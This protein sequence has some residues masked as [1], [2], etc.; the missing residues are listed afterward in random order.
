MI[1][2]NI[3]KIFVFCI[4]FTLLVSSPSFAKVRLDVGEVDKPVAE[5]KVNTSEGIIIQSNPYVERYNETGR[6]T[7]KAKEEYDSVNNF[8]IDLKTLELRVKYFSP[9]YLNIRQ[10]A[11][12][13][14]YMAYYARGGNDTLMYDALSYTEEIHDL[15]DDYKELYLMYTRERNALDKSDPDYATKYATLTAQIETYQYMH[16]VAKA[17]YDATNRTINSTKTMLGL[18]NALYNIGNVDNNNQITFAREAITKGLIT[19]VLSVLQLETYIDILEN[20]TNLYYD[21]YE[22]NKKNLGL[23]LATEN[24]VLSSYS[25][26][27]T[28]KDTLKK[29][30][31]TLRNVKEQ[32]ANNLG[33]SIN[34]VDKLNFVEPEVDYEY[35]LSI[36]VGAD[37]V[38]AYTSNSNYYSLSINSRDRKRPGSTGEALL[39]K[40]QNYMSEKVITAFE[41]TYNRL[42]SARLSYE[43]GNILNNVCLIN[44]EANKRKLDNN[45]VSELEYKGLELQNFANVL[46]VRVSKYSLISAYMDYYYATLGHLDIA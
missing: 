38:K 30:K 37:E 20:Q 44:L 4:A 19:A 3:K 36:D 41:D 21:M 29:T 42:E 26:Y 24:D 31:T 18:S 14:Y 13:S 6:L 33:Y 46:Q 5:P 25:T 43:A 39:S 11:V 34:D 8:N 45:L 10:G 27:E 16:K 7:G 9:T 40:R 1:M 17:T 28:A 35:L 23:G 15:M 2:F 32:V 22:L 12:S